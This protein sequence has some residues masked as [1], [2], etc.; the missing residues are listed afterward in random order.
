MHQRRQWLL[1]EAE[2]VLGTA[3][4]IAPSRP[5]SRGAAARACPA[6]RIA[7]AFHEA[8]ESLAPHFGY[9]TREES[10]VP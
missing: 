3:T 5:R 8:Y 6:E 10:A 1:D 9:Q 7:R 4:E 2:E